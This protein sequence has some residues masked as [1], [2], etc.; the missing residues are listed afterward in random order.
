M[1]ITKN[2]GF[3]VA[4]VKGKKERWGISRIKHFKQQKISQVYIPPSLKLKFQVVPIKKGN[5]RQRTSIFIAG[6]AG[7]GKTK[8]GIDFMKEYQKE[9][10]D[11]LCIIITPDTEDET[12]QENMFEGLKILDIDDE[13]FMDPEALDITMF[14]DCIVYVDDNE[15]LEGDL[16]K[17]V[18]SIKKRLRGIGRHYNCSLIES[19]HELN[20]GV[21]TKKSIQTSDYVTAFPMAES[22]YSLQYFLK[23]HLGDRKGILYDIIV[24]KSNSRWVTFKI[25]F[26][27]IIITSNLLLLT[28]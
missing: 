1:E 7:S 22:S 18:K 20:G 16:K 10:P 21:K 5:E 9:F 14:R 6:P 17:R 13:E 15:Y 11:N 24:K 26:P 27:Q 19:G 3:I 12:I 8:W 28:N 2:K 23:K 4:R 25:S